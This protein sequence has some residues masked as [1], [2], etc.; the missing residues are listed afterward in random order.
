M[1]FLQ[2]VLAYAGV[3]VIVGLIGYYSGIFFAKSRGNDFADFND[4]EQVIWLRIFMFIFSFVGAVVW[5]I[6][7]IFLTLAWIIF[8]LGKIAK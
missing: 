5:P 2:W 1:T 3:A 8:F 4:K 6:T 7:I